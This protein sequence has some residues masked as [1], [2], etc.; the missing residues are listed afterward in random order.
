MFL[1]KSAPCFQQKNRKKALTAPLISVIIFSKFHVVPVEE[2]V[3]FIILGGER[4]CCGETKS[5]R[6]LIPHRGSHAQMGV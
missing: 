1:T 2:V 4:S 5:V 3:L 6:D